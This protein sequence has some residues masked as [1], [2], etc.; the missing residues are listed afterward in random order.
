LRLS[1][2]QATLDEPRARALEVEPGRYVVV[3]VRD[4]GTGLDAEVLEHLFEPFFT[5]KPVGRG[6]GLG[7]AGVHGVVRQHGGAVEVET[8]AGRGTTFRLVLPATEELPAEPGPEPSA[9]P[10]GSESVLVV[11]DDAGVRRFVVQ[12]LGSLGYQVSAAEDAAPALAL[13]RARGR[14]FDLVVTDVVMPGRS[15]RELFEILRREGLA[16]R[17]LFVSGYPRDVFG[18]RAAPT[19]GAHLLQKPFAIR[20]LGL[21]VR[22]ALDGPL[23]GGIDPDTG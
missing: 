7:L 16:M 17:V 15:G 6:T 8:A 13:S 22:Q 9:V 23:P 4:T 10:R 14:P 21:A 20:D 3:E 19:D 2:G 5:T 1:T 11:E 12:A 18:D